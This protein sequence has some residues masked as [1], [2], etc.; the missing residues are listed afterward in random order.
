[1]RGT[2]RGKRGGDSPIGIFDSGIGGLSVLQALQAELPGERFVYLADNGYAPYGERGDE[3]VLARTLV[4]ARH[5]LEQ[6]GIKALVIACNTATAA[7][8][9]AVRERYPGMTVVGVEPALKPAI[10]LSRTGHVGVIA[11]RGTVNST[12]FQALLG[13][14]QARHA[15]RA[16][17][18]VQACDGL[19][20]AIEQA[21]RQV[22]AANTMKI[23]AL[24]AEYT[25]AMGQFG[26]QDSDIDTL[27]LG[28]THYVFARPLLQACVGADI[29]LL[30]NGPAVARHT[31]HLLATGDLLAPPQATPSLH[32]CTTGDPV[33]LQA[34][35]ARWLASP[36]AAVTQIDL[37]H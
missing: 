8:V 27:V 2:A 30:D 7:A 24:C 18:T 14:L 34:A 4:V 22:D 1:M 12:K 33:I 19:A 3:F 26:H 6:H 29:Q 13:S 36:L 20:A 31:H 5:L 10:A 16:R 11:T 32:G 23:R 37:P 35:V 25:G 17:F 15:P 28:C 21:A 9:Q